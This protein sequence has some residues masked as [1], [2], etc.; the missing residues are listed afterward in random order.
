M[1]LVPSVLRGLPVQLVLSVRKALLEKLVLPALRGL[2]VK[3]A[4]PVLKVLLV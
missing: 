1:F 4:L 2:P 3:L